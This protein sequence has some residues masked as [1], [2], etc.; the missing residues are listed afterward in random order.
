M[1]KDNT[2]PLDVESTDHEQLE[3]DHDVLLV[4]SELDPLIQPDVKVPSKEEANVARAQF[5]ALCWTMFVMGW[6]NSSTG[7]LLPRIQFFYEVSWHTSIRYSF[8]FLSFFSSF[9]SGLE[10]RL[11][12][13]SSCVRSV[14]WMFIGIVNRCCCGDLLIVL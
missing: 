6:T 3:H 2:K 10:Q 8:D 14:T 5:L 9:R 4:Q 1:F 7:P 11:G 12:Y 13:L